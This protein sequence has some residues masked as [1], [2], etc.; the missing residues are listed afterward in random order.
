MIPPKKT[1]T[2]VKNETGRKSPIAEMRKTSRSDEFTST[3][4]GG[5]SASFSPYEFQE[6][7][8]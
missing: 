3:G 7:R 6:V 2:H 8:Q 4:F 5:R 1:E